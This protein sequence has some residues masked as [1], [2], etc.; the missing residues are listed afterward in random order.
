MLNEHSITVSL[1][2]R[3]RFVYIDYYAGGAYLLFRPRNTNS[4]FSL[5]FF[6]SFFFGNLLRTTHLL[7]TKLVI[8]LFIHC[9][10]FTL[11]SWR[12]HT[13]ML[14]YLNV[15]SKY[16]SRLFVCLFIR[17]FSSLNWTVNK[18]WWFCRA[19]CRTIIKSATI[20]FFSLQLNL[21][22]LFE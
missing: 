16:R 20:V 14:H 15:T 10:S 6:S 19:C 21:F 9:A 5:F 3:T 18:S 22:H 7:C 11:L 12:K 2:E 1:D 13:N 17:L 8:F 4:M